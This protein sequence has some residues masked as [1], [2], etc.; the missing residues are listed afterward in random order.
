MS[1]ETRRSDLHPVPRPPGVVT[2]K[3]RYAPRS[4][5]RSANTQGPIATP[6]EEQAP[7]PYLL[8]RDKKGDVDYSR[9]ARLAVDGAA[10]VSEY[11]DP[12][13]RLSVAAY[14]I[15]ADILNPEGSVEEMGDRIAETA[16][17]QIEEASKRAQRRSISAIVAM[18]LRQ[19][20]PE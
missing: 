4:P 1:S 3:H 13:I 8:Q 19:Q 6:S 2:A 17:E 16:Q 18:H 14:A 10:E 12:L 7:N 20:A 15:A 9:V 11:D 5:R